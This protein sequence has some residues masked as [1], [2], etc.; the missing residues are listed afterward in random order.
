VILNWRSGEV[1]AKGEGAGAI[2][3]GEVQEM[4]CRSSQAENS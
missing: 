4:R 3:S 1:E 2:R